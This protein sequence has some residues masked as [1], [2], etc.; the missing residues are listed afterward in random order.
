[1]LKQFK[2]FLNTPYRKVT[3][4]NI[5]NA[6][7]CTWN[8]YSQ[9]R[10]LSVKHKL[11][12]YHLPY[13]I[14]QQQYL[15]YKRW[16]NSLDFN[17]KLYRYQHKETIFRDITEVK[18][19][20]PD[21]QRILKESIKPGLTLKQKLMHFWSEIKVEGPLHIMIPGIL[22]NFLKYLRSAKWLDSFSKW[23][24][25]YVN[26]YHKALQE[27][28]EGHREVTKNHSTEINGKTVEQKIK[29]FEEKLQSNQFSYEHARSLI[30]N[31]KDENN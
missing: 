1:M 18:Y 6:S 8:Y 14:F 24:I 2:E 12:P 27:L 21:R 3:P 7:K 16:K 23:I 9:R 17:T 30:K 25:T 29:E 26:L 19:F 10:E 31:K 11:R 5:W 13:L 28:V 15:D 20:I 22:Q 4:I